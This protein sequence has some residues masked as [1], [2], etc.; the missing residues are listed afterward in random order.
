MPKKFLNPPLMVK[1]H[2]LFPDVGAFA[3]GF[4]VP[5]SN[6]TYFQFDAPVLWFV[7]API[8]TNTSEVGV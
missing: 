4:A 7:M 6:F 5:H 8:W 3:N 1:V 2:W